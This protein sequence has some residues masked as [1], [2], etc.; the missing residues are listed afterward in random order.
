[1]TDT[2]VLDVDI[3]DEELERIALG[4]KERN[5]TGWMTTCPANCLVM[6]CMGNKNDTRG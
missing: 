4:T 1:M 3:S 2:D 5:D 6:L